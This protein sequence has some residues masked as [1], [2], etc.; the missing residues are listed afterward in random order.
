[1][2]YQPKT[3]GV[4][5][6]AVIVASFLKI[7]S[8][9]PDWIGRD[10]A[11]TPEPRKRCNWTMVRETLVPVRATMVVPV[12]QESNTKLLRI[13]IQSDSMCAMEGDRANNS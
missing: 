9:T 13:G 8:T 1:M 5:L 12:R 7:P 2:R 6:S 10:E 4:F 3:E 11:I